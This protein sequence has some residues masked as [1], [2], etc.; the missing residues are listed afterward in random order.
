MDLPI[1]GEPH[2]VECP[3]TSTCQGVGRGRTGLGGTS[4][5]VMNKADQSPH[6][7]KQRLWHTIVGGH[8]YLRQVKQDSSPIG[9]RDCTKLPCEQVPTCC[10]SS[11][12]CN[13]S[14]AY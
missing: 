3:P 5:N 13:L 12:T 1:R 9:H 8:V 7:G 14:F 2:K 10:G 6:T 4:Q 11:P